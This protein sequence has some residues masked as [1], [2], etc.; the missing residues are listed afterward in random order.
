M[1]E[2]LADVTGGRVLTS[3]NPDD[4]RDAFTSIVREF[5]SRYVLTYTPKNVE[6]TGWHP[7]EV[8]LKQPQRNHQ[9]AARLH[10]LMS[11]HSREVAAGPVGVA[12]RRAFIGT[13]WVRVD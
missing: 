1:L 2:S 4:L 9:G 10:A 12:A 7:I 8:K 11:E 13:G 6:T 5:R 3:R